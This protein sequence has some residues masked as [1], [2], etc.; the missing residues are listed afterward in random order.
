MSTGI[1]SAPGSNLRHFTNGDNSLDR[2]IQPGPHPAGDRYLSVEAQNAGRDAGR[3]RTYCRSLGILRDTSTRPSSFASG[4]FESY[5]HAEVEIAHQSRSRSA[6][7]SALPSGRPVAG[8]SCMRYGC[9]VRG[10]ESDDGWVGGQGAVLNA[11]QLE[12]GTKAGP[13]TET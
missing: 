2:C 4:V 3:Y 12:D 5:P 1:A 9:L 7:Q 6:S 11:G 10:V 13:E 8:Q